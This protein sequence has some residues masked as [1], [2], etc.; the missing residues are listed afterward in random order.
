MSWLAELGRTTRELVGRAPGAQ[1]AAIDPEWRE[2]HGR[3]GDAPA[4]MRS[5]AWR[6]DVLSW[7]RVATLECPGRCT[8][9]SALAIPHAAHALPLFGAEVVEVRGRIT[10]VAIDWIPILPAD[11]GAGH[12]IPEA[13][14]IRSRH[15]GFPPGDD[16]PP[17]AE[18]SFS[19]HALFSRPKAPPD[20]RRLRA[21]LEDYLG[22]YLAACTASEPRADPASVRAAQEAYCREHFDNDPGG[23]M[24]RTIFGDAWAQGYARAFLFRLG[25]D[26]AAA[27]ASSPAEPADRRA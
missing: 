20:A 11:R 10:V 22:A 15:D 21:A 4:T 13:A 1:D 9:F 5:R 12:A 8:V 24:L 14:A 18:A 25:D 19:P 6:T 17:W 2:A 7:F 27:S 23:T 3:L 26:P 16:L